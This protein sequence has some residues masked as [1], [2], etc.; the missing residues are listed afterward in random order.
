VTTG[1]GAMKLVTGVVWTQLEV[2]TEGTHQQP[3]QNY[4]LVVEVYYLWLQL[5]VLLHHLSSF[6]YIY[7]N[8]KN[9]SNNLKSN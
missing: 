9:V 2:V 7:Y 6:A 4:Q 8:T 5:L 1:H 3:N